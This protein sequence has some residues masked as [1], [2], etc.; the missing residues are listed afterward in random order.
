[1]WLQT[2]V[3]PTK[4]YICYCS[5]TFHLPHRCLKLASCMWCWNTVFGHLALM[6]HYDLQRVSYMLPI[7]IVIQCPT[8]VAFHLPPMNVG[9]ECPEK[10]FSFNSFIYSFVA[11]REANI[12][13][14]K[15]LFTRFRNSGPHDWTHSLK[16]KKCKFFPG[17]PIFYY[18]EIHILLKVSPYPHISH[19][20]A[21][22]PK[23]FYFSSEGIPAQPTGYKPPVHVTD[24]QKLC[25]LHSFSPHAKF[26]FSV[27]PVMVRSFFSFSNWCIWIHC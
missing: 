25:K 10:F 13:Q 17:H 8:S 6:M 16:K 12:R 24:F 21:M 14:K 9:R 18:Y 5:V 27:I 3:L 15:K 4:G 11:Q 2:Q 26:E 7:A 19:G 23:G 1:M 20:I 22:W